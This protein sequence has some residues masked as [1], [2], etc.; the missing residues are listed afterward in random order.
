LVNLC[1]R[2]G[3]L[4]FYKEHTPPVQSVIQGFDHFS[5]A[6]GLKAN[7]QNSRAFI[8]S[9]TSHVKEEIPTNHRLHTK[10]PSQSN[11]WGSLYPL[12]RW[13]KADCDVL[14]ENN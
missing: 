14:V 10:G 13:T 1:F 9:V 12:E 7:H 2:D 11:T 3:L 8:A 6:T 4:I 5:G